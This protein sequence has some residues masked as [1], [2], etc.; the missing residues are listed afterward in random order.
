MCINFGIWN[1]Y[2]KI[3]YYHGVLAI[4]FEISFS[5]TFYSIFFVCSFIFV[6]YRIISVQIAK[7]TSFF[8]FF[9]FYNYCNYTMYWVAIDIV[10]SVLSLSSANFLTSSCDEPPSVSPLIPCSIPSHS[11][12]AS[13][14]M[15]V[16]QSCRDLSQWAP[17]KSCRLMSCGRHC[18][19]EAS[20][21]ERWPTDLHV[22][23]VA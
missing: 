17:L 7:L 10:R 16:R 8:F 13:S 11:P 21:S 15:L 3:Y 4:N 14:R 20:R 22:H 2:P 6:M 12:F 18:L 19:I 5:I 1:L 9:F 23:G